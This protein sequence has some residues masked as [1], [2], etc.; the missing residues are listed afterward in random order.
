M[1]LECHFNNVDLTILILNPISPT[2]VDPV[3]GV[4]RTGNQARSALDAVFKGRLGEILNLDHWD[5]H[6]KAE[7]RIGELRESRAGSE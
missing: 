5:S 2:R 6:V 7:T 1:P 4:I 3:D